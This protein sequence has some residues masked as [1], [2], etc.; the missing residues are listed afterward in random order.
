MKMEFGLNGFLFQHDPSKWE[1]I[2][3]PSWLKFTWKFLCKNDVQLRDDIS[4]FPPLREQDRNIMEAFSELGWPGSQIYKL[5]ICRM[6]LQV[7]TIAEITTGD[8]TRITHD[9]WTG[10]KDTNRKTTY[11]WPFQPIPP[12]SFWDIWKKAL[13]SLC[14]RQYVLTVPLGK[15]T[16]AG[17]TSSMWWFDKATES[18]FQAT[19]PP[20]TFPLKSTRTTRFAELR[21]NA[22]TTVS[23]YIPSSA[24]PCSVSRQGNFWTYQGSADI[25]PSLSQL[26]T[27][28]SFEEF[29]AAKQVNRWVYDKLQTT[30]SLDALARAI[31]Q[32]TWTCVADGSFKN[33]HGTAAWKILDLDDPTNSIEGQCVTPGDPGHQNPY[34]SELSGLFM[35]I[36]MTN[37]LIDYFQVTTG[38]ITLACDNLGAITTTEYPPEGT[39]PSAC[40]QFD[41]VMAIQRKKSKKITWNHLHVYGHQDTKSSKPLTPIELINVEMDTKAKLHWAETE[42]IAQPDR[43]LCFDGEPWSLYIANSKVVKLLSKEISEWCQCPRIQL[44]G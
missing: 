13:A 6:F 41:L 31:S 12:P 7:I 3:T 25:L 36:T 38:S 28:R 23:S 10:K 37:A 11:L 32:G 16:D 18:L 43:I 4:D 5:N 8:G 44:I 2:I 24:I 26:P 17:A 35:G 42:H 30:G 33:E 1:A 22:N 14:G 39:S 34:R 27:A 15:W 29:I 20:I 21:Y 19:N 9:A 40:A